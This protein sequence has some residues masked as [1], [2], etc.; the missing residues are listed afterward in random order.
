[1]DIN[2]TAIERYI[3]LFGLQV[4]LMILGLVGMAFFSGVAPEDNIASAVL[5]SLGRF[6]LPASAG[7]TLIASMWLAWNCCTAKV[8]AGR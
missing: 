1:M 8:V 4:F 6:L 2:I 5:A 3:R 7:V